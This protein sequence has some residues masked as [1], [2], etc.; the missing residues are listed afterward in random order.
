LRWLPIMAAALV[1]G[2]VGCGS[3]ATGDGGSG[4]PIST[5][6]FTTTG[7]DGA[8]VTVP[9]GKPAVF[10][11]FTTSCSQGAPA[12]ASAHRQT[13]GATYVAVDLDP[14]A[15]EAGARGV[16]RSAGA[17][18]AGLVVSTDTSIV[19]TF[20]VSTLGTTVVL[21]ATGKTVYTRV[22]ATAGEITTAVA[23]AQQ[24]T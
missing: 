13:P 5:G 2:C 12:V 23:A 7:P 10:Y 14:G 22:E 11:F 20:G 6:R 21:D 17:N 3:T 4:G 8:S 9:D 15:T 1:A 24:R 18:E 16:L 19:T